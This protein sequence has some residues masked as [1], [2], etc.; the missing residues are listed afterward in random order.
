MENNFKYT[1]IGAG[2]IGLAISEKLSQYDDGILVV[3]KEKKFGL[4]TSSRNSEVVHS[5]FY[6]PENSLKSK[7]CVAGNTLM[8]NFCD[9]YNI[10]YKKCGK[11]I[12]ANSKEDIE[13]LNAILLLAQKNGIKGARI[14]SKKESLII[15]P[16]VQCEK[17][18]WIPSTGIVDSHLVMSK[19]ENLSLSR[20]VSILYNLE[21]NGIKKIDNGYE[22]DFINDNSTIRT[23]YIINCAGLWAHKIANQLLDKKYE[24]EYYKGDYFKTSD[25]RD[26][27]CLIYPVPEPLSLGA[28]VVINLSGEVL[29]GPNVYKVTDISYQNDDRYKKDFL[30]YA[31]KLLTDNVKNIYI[32]YSGIRPKVKY[33]GKIND[34]IIKEE[35]GLK[36][37][38]NLIGIDSPGL[39]S[40]LA[41][42]DYVQHLIK[43]N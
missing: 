38:Y 33:N 7:L 43:S 36:N 35:E 14:I 34:F 6:Y 21:L 13:K 41:I 25:V 32:D 17:S 9:K 12:A 29:F 1:I 19:L 37:F 2:I 16:K 3:E 8:Y 30:K 18:L 31:N 10:P 4:H 39:T 24:V 40:S 23:E 20:D 11:L 42:A 22:I 5:G 26:L 27:S 15:E 28:H